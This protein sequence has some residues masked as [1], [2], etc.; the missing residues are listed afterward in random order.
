ML[1]GLDWSSVLVWP[2][3]AR[4]VSRRPGAAYHRCVLR[5]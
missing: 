1:D 2:D 3:D 4:G 5:R